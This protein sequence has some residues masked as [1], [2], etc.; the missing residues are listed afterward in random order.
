MMRFR[1]KW[2]GGVSAGVLGLL[3]FMTASRARASVTVL[4]EQPYGRLGIIDP[5]GHSAVYLDH[6]CAETPTR[7][8]PCEP[9]EMG[10]VL[11]RY[12]GIVHYDWLAT[13]LLPYLYAVDSVEQIPDSVGRAQVT[14]LRDNYRR[15]YLKQL[16]P[17]MPDGTAPAG[18]WYEMAGSA[19]DRTIYGFQARTTAEQ[20]AVLIAYFNDSDNI[21][22]YNGI[23]RNCAD[24]V[25]V[26]LNLV[27]PHAIHRNWIADLGMT[28]P[29][30]VARGLAHY[31]KKHPGTDL[32][33]FVVPQVKGELPRSH[34]AQDFAQGIL[35]RFGLPIA[36][37]SPVT[38]GV[39]IA[40]FIGHGRFPMPKDAP[41]LD[42]TRLQ[43]QMEIARPFPIEMPQLPEALFVV[44]TKEATPAVPAG[45]VQPVALLH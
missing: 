10:V 26:A 28:S 25:R 37:L 38:T 41:V 31:A 13:P 15:R 2:R 32:R 33:A 19:Y 36:I 34:G 40:A 12:D 9:G 1:G 30:S 17:D 43:A 27:Y 44:V 4:L 22:H 39:V 23:T 6:V 8:R 21:S 3:S 45:I 5:A 16:A 29:K 11:S 18:N 42:L 7:L 14:Q 35:T 24:F 20:D